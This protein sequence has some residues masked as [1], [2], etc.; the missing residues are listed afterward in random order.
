MKDA[1]RANFDASVS[2][3]DA[4]ER[5]TGHFATLTR[6]LHAEMTARAGDPVAAVLDAGA[7]S[8]VSTA[9][10][11]PAAAARLVALDL[12]RAMLRENGARARVQGDFDYLPFATGAFD[13]VAYTASLF[14]V[15]DPA[16]AVAEARRVLRPG[17]VLGAV[18]PAGMETLDGEDLFADRDRQARSP[19][20]AADLEAAVAAEFAVET[21]TWRVPM[22]AE[23]VRAFHAIP[24]MAARLY[25][26]L[27][28]EERVERAQALLADLEGTVEHRWRWV[29]GTAR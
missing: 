12:S 16:V 14:L 15:P 9:V 29:V 17:G 7:G 5:R 13:A 10:L 18:A 20:A 2:A 8:G 11:E 3:Y 19:T 6:L 1:V 27:R 28:P 4:F 23:D 21:G 25:P 26:R 24:A 22:T